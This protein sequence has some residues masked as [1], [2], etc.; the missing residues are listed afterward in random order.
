MKAFDRTDEVG[1]GQTGK[2]E[3]WLLFLLRQLEG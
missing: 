2:K 1:K 3:K